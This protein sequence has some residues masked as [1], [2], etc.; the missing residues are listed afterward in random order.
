[1]QGRKSWPTPQVFRATLSNLASVGR[2]AE[3]LNSA[4]SLIAVIPLDRVVVDFTAPRGACEMMITV[5]LE[6]ELIQTQMTQKPLL[7]AEGGCVCVAQI[8]RAKIRGRGWPSSS[9]RARHLWVVRTLEMHRGRRLTCGTRSSITAE[10]KKGLSTHKAPFA[11][12]PGK[13]PDR[14]RAP[15]S[16]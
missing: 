11:L 8:T 3:K 12:P 1:V 9:Q 16:A 7:R 10:V 14:A 15:P 4:N 5:E 6:L 2:C 13:G